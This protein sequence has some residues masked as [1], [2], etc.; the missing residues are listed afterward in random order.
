M[1]T[2]QISSTKRT[3]GTNRTRGTKR[4]RRITNKRRRGP[5]PRGIETVCLYAQARHCY[6]NKHKKNKIKDV[7]D[8]QFPL[9]RF[10]SGHFLSGQLLLGA[11]GFA[12][13]NPTQ[14]ILPCAFPFLLSAFRFDRRLQSWRV[15]APLD[16][17]GDHSIARKV[18]IKELIN[19]TKSHHST[20]PQ[21]PVSWQP[22][23]SQLFLLFSRKA[24]ARIKK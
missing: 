20:C 24:R 19:C 10:L 2:Q 21:I 6:C 9:G 7:S 17:A 22:R 11:M 13:G 12:S 1:N 5:L 23:V 3:R 16:H 15:H 18:D 14:P 8:A 4:A